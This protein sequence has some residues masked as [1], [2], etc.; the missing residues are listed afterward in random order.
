MSTLSSTPC[1]PAVRR[2]A[3]RS[4]DPNLPPWRTPS[5]RYVLLG[6]TGVRVSEVCLGTMTFG[7]EADEAASVAIMDQALAL[8]I[9]FF[10]TANIY[11]GGLTEEIVGRWLVAHREAIVLATKAHFPAG[12]G[13]NDRGSSRRHL[14]LSVEQSLRRLK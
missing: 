8:G 11:N 9:N 14:R 13:P 7:N 5:M 1:S 4:L 12:P 6:R 2:T 10:D 3:S